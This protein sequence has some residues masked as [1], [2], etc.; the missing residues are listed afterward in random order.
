MGKA[1]IL[2]KYRLVGKTATLLFIFSVTL[3]LLFLT[4]N[5]SLIIS[6]IF[7]AAE[8]FFDTKAAEVSVSA[9]LSVF[10]ILLLLF[11]YAPFRLGCERWFLLSAKGE[12]A[13]IKEVFYYFNFQGLAKSVSAFLLCFFKKCAALIL[14][15]FPSVCLFSVLYFS[16]KEGEISLTVSYA[17]SVC[18]LL[19]FLTGVLF[20]FFYSSRFFAYYDVII[21]NEKIK[22]QSA[23]EKSLEITEGAYAKICIFRLSFLPWLLLC[24]LI[25]PA[26]YVWGYYRESKTM[27]CLRNDLL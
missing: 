26:F 9:A 14:F 12:K 18:S 17:L 2:A 23:F 5:F 20:Y 25:F 10:G 15:L 8:I 19:L 1:K 27:L 3:A 22:P 7:G 6:K 11:I 4:G 24:M 16:L 13:G 21:S